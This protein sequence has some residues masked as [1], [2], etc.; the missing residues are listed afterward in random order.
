[1]QPHKLKN[2]NFPLTWKLIGQHLCVASLIYKKFLQS[3]STPSP[4][5]ADT[6]NILIKLFVAAIGGKRQKH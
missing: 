2:I 5:P 1:M 6:E 4:S 3:N